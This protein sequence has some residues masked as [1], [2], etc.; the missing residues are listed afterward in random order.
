MIKY[1]HFLCDLRASARNNLVRAE[2]PR[3][4]RFGADIATL[5]CSAAKEEK[6]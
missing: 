4:Q 3:S 1:L 2:T 5:A 6:L